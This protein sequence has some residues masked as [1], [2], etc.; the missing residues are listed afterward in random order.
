MHETMKATRIFHEQIELGRILRVVRAAL[1]LC[2]M[3]PSWQHLT[4]AL[5]QTTAL[6]EVTHFEVV[7]AVVVYE[8]GETASTIVIANHSLTQMTQLLRGNTI[9]LSIGQK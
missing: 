3:Q 9:Q 6:S 2:S 5:F 4:N 7:T 1:G 8:G